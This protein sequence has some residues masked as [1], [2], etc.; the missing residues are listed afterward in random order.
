[1]FLLAMIFVTESAVAVTVPLPTYQHQDPITGEILTCNRCP[2]GHHMH[3]HCTATHQ[4]KCSPCKPEHFT[5]YWNYLSKCLYCNNF[6]GENEFIKQ[7]CSPLNNRVCECKDGYY[8]N[9]GLCMRHKECPPGYGVEQRGT[10]FRDTGCAKCSP[11][12][13]SSSSSAL[14]ACRNHTDCSSLGLETV[15]QGAAWHDSI[16]A[17]CEDLKARD[18]LVYLK[19]ILPDF[20]AHQKMKLR[21]MQRLTRILR[22]KNGKKLRQDT[23]D[24]NAQKVLQ[25]AVSEWIKDATEERLRALP[26]ILS[27]LR[28]NNV[29]D[30]LVRKINRVEGTYLCGNDI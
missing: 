17:S 19:E 15:M 4:T 7:E 29:A 16:C 21:K 20:F 14:E 26:E 8:R 6:C 24:A 27:K 28:L 23:E 9:Y 25:S 3:A 11:S 5:Q 30:K 13:Y 2:P 22:Q 10:A 1:M 12:S 18:R